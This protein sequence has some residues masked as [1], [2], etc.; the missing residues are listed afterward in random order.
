M[1]TRMI[2]CICEELLDLKIATDGQKIAFPDL[3]F[4]LT[5]YV[6]SNKLE[7]SAS[8]TRSWQSCKWCKSGEAHNG[9]R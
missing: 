3:Q 9:L 2:H 4:K 8:I 1:R 6:M 5:R 7:F